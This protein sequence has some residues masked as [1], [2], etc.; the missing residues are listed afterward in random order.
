[1]KIEKGIPIPCK[2]GRHVKVISPM[3]VGDSILLDCKGT[4]DN[5]VR[6]VRQAGT[7]IGFK[8]L[9]RTCD[10]GVRVWRVK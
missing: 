10:A 4:Q 2:Q 7:T 6:C 3:Q 9:A 8:L 5:L 1:M